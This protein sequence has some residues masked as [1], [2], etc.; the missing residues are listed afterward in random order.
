M[1]MVLF[2]PED[3]F[4]LP[5]EFGSGSGWEIGSLSKETKEIFLDESTSIFV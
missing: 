5:E 4:N 3:D 2:S 1:D